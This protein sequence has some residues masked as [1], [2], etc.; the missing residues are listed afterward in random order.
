MPK[1]FKRIKVSYLRKV[2]GRRRRVRVSYTRRVPVRRLRKRRLKKR[3]PRPVKKPFLRRKKKRRLSKRQQFA[4]RRRRQHSIQQKRPKALIAEKP[5]FIPLKKYLESLTARYGKGLL[6]ADETPRWLK[7]VEVNSLFWAWSKRY[8]PYHGRAFY[9]KIEMWYV[10]ER[11]D[12]DT[13]KSRFY[14]WKNSRAQGLEHGVEWRRILAIKADLENDIVE[15]ISKTSYLTF[16]GFVGW[17]VY[18]DA[19][20]YNKKIQYRK[21]LKDRQKMIDASEYIEEPFEQ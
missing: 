11:F 15:M 12:E 1:K 10:V 20:W 7:W 6:G 21:Y 4:Y 5:R 19:D 13:Q 16:H 14:L 2:R 3:V 17:S 8:P 9:V 18:P